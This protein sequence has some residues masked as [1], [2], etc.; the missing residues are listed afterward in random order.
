MA[1]FFVIERKLCT[2]GVAA[3]RHDGFIGDPPT[4]TVGSHLTQKKGNNISAVAYC[5]NFGQSFD[6]LA[7]VDLRR[8]ATKLFYRVIPNSV[9][10]PRPVEDSDGHSAA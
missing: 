4:V 7:L 6:V 5:P 8:A 3:R 10:R 2:A 1:P 9:D